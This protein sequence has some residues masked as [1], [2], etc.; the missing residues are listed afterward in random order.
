MGYRAGFEAN[1]VLVT[2]E[3]KVSFPLGAGKLHLEEILKEMAKVRASVGVSILSMLEE[4]VRSDMQNIEIFIL[5]SY[6]NDEIEDQIIGFQTHGNHVQIVRL[7]AAGEKG[8]G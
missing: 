3:K 4:G 7:D 6:I 2:G 8:E 5:T 1:C